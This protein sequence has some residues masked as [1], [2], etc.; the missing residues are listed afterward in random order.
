MQ[1]MLV[2]PT[3]ACLTIDLGTVKELG[4]MYFHTKLGAY[5]SDCKFFF[6]IQPPTPVQTPTCIGG[7]DLWHIQSMYLRAGSL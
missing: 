6:A 5:T 1:M 3:A 7:S 4:M 2:C